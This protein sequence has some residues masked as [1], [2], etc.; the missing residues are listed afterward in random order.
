M[1]TNMRRLLLV[2]VLL[3]AVTSSCVMPPQNKTQAVV[4][5]IIFVTWLVSLPFILGIA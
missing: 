2:A 5:V 4:N 3:V 1:T